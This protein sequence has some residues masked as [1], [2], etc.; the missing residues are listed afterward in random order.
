M[1]GIYSCVAP[2]IFVCAVVENVYMVE[3][4]IYL[5]PTQ[6]ILGQH[7]HADSIILAYLKQSGLHFAE[8]RY[9]HFEHIC[10]HQ[11]LIGALRVTSMHHA[12]GFKQEFEVTCK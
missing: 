11:V 8:L 9:S 2:A 10:L 12:T 6:L 4:S 7:M 1:K 3:V 5:H